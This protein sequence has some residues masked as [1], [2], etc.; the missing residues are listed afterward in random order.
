LLGSESAFC[1][2][3][4]VQGSFAKENFGLPEMF[5]SK[6]ITGDGTWIHHCE[7][8]TNSSSCNGNIMVLPLPRN[9]GHNLQQCF[10]T[11]REFW[12][13]ATCHMRQQSLMMPLL[14]YFRI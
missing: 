12:S 4:V 13:W 8:E 5:L 1:P 3:E 14:L 10:G 9:F 7:P 6:M 11:W 2:A